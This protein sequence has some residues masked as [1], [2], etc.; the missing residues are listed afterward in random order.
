MD[1]TPPT[2]LLGLRGSLASREARGL[3]G[4]REAAY[5]PIDETEHT[6]S[7]VKFSRWEKT[8]SPMPHDEEEAIFSDVPMASFAILSLALVVVS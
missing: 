5:A 8:A 6:G 4:A 1:S 3:I 2:Q 7:F